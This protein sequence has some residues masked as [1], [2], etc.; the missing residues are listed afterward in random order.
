VF[1]PNG[2]KKMLVRSRVEGYIGPLP[3][4]LRLVVSVDG[5]AARACAPI[6]REAAACCQHER[7]H[8]WFAGAR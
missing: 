6:L 5:E 7:G 8:G 4:T 3:S 2:L 1:D